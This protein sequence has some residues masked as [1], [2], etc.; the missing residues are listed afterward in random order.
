MRRC[1]VELAGLSL[2]GLGQIYQGLDVVARLG[3]QNQ[4]ADADGGDRLQ[5]GIGV[6]L[7]VFV[8]QGRDGAHGGRHKANRVAVIG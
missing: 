7:R 1:K 5:I 3:D 8:H 6:E 4:R 2:G